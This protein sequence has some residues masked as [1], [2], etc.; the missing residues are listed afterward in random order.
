MLGVHGMHSSTH[1]ICDFCDVTSAHSASSEHRKAPTTTAALA[2][3]EQGFQ[4]LLW[5][6]RINK[7]PQ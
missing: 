1:N 4:G 6:Y 5:F 3:C 7:T 2:H